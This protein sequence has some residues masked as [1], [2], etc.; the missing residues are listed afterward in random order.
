MTIH[1]VRLKYGQAEQ[2]AT[3]LRQLYRKAMISVDERTN[4]LIVQI[5]GTSLPEELK[6]L[7]EQLDQ[8]GEPGSATVTE[9]DRR[10]LPTARVRRRRTRIAEHLC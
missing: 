6:A 8:P 7:I 4:S 3:I 2:M 5:E 1:V 10:N 9:P